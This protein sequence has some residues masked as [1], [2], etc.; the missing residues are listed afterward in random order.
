MLSSVLVCCVLLGL[1]YK[2]G[3]P[4]ARVIDVRFEGVLC[5]S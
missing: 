4:N 1:F 5:E 2:V 3:R